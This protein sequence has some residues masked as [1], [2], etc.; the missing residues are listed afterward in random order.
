MASDLP[1]S[2]TVLIVDDEEEVRHILRVVCE[3]EGFEVVGEAVHGVEA[4]S[5]AMR[6]QPA[7]IILD[8]FMP[9]LDGE[10]AAR[11]LRTISPN[12]RIVAFSAVLTS[13][14]DWSDSFLNK[15]RIA[16]VAP[17]LEALL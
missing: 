17:V 11:M 13:K 1:K 14:P 15:K 2:R 5:I 10:H 7:V 16:E 9:K 6:E 12:S 3:T 4:V 8:Y